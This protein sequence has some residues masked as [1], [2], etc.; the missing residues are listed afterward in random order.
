MMEM[1]QS[2]VQ[3]NSRIKGTQYI[4]LC[5]IEQSTVTTHVLVKMYTYEEPFSNLYQYD[6]G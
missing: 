6:T 1:H 5:F 2:P 3:E 4:K